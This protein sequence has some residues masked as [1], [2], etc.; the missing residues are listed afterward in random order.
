MPLRPWPGIALV[1]GVG[2]LAAAFFGPRAEAGE[3]ARGGTLRWNFAVDFPTV[4]PALNYTSSFWTIERVTCST[5]LGFADDEGAS[6]SRPIPEVAAA[7]PTQSKDG[8]TYT[9]TLRRNFRFQTGERVTAR[10]YAHAWNRA[11]NP[12]LQSPAQHFMAVIEGAQDV[13]DGRA[14]NAT[15]VQAVDDWTLRVRLTDVAPD[16]LTRVTM[17]FFC[18]LPVDTPANRELD[19]APVPGSGPYYLKDWTRRRLA[20]IARNPYYAGPRAANVDEIQITIGVALD[21]TVLQVEKGEADLGA[22]PPE[23]VSH[24]V[25]TYGINK[26]R[27][28][29]RKTIATWYF[30]FNHDRP[31]FKN[32]DRLK[33]ALNHAID[34]PALVRQHGYL[35]GARTDQILPSAMPGFREWDLYSLKRADIE[36]A[37]RELRAGDLRAGKATLL[38]G[39]VGFGPLVAQVFQYN[40]KQIG[41]EVELRPLNPAVANSLASTRGADFDIYLNGWGADYPD[42]SNF[43]NV[44][45]LGGDN[46]RAENNQNQSYFD[47]PAFNR[48]MQRAALLTGDSRY[49]LF[50][51]LDRDLMRGPA[52]VA[53]Y[54]NTNTRIFVSSRVKNFKYSGA[55]GTLLNVLTLE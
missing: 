49:E 3:A 25:N 41:L 10:S 8:K 34:R 1:A 12:K 26:G 53:P 13:F 15:G 23:S 4:D 29:V 22:F 45:L 14:E 24:L 6:A 21:A 28:F 16:F 50:A 40:A 54:L 19:T 39:N 51:I 11:M 36:R 44:L 32:N 9:F 27:F 5:L 48:R 17:P 43:V 35:A 42:P 46:I 20:R 31:L 52:P 37:K 30:A 38:F 7:L 47:H 18:P 2:L 55:K 33:R